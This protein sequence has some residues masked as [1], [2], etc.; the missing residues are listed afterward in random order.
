MLDAKLWGA[1]RQRRTILSFPDAKARTSSSFLG[2]DIPFSKDTCRQERKSFWS[3]TAPKLHSGYSGPLRSESVR[4]LPEVTGTWHESSDERV[5]HDKV[6]IITNDQG[7]RTTPSY[8]AF[9]DTD[10]FVGDSAKNQVSTNPTNTVFDAKRLIGRRFSDVSVQ[11]DIKH[12]PFKVIAGPGDKPMVEVKYKGKQKQ[13]AA[14]EISSMVLKKKREIAEAFVGTAVT[15]AV[16]TVPAYFSDSQRQ[17]TEEAATQCGLQVLKIIAE[18][19]AAAIAYGLDRQQQGGIAASGVKNV[20]IFDLGGG[21]C[22]VSLLAIE[23]GVIRV[24]ATD[25]NTRLGGVDFNNRMVDYFVEEFKRKNK[26]DISG[27]ARALHRLRIACESAKRTLSSTIQTSIEIDYLSEGVNFSSTITRARFEQLNMDLFQKCIEHVDTCLAKA[28]ID[29]TAVDD[30]VIIGG[31]SRIPKLQQLLQDFF[32][33]KNLC[34]H[35]NADEA[36]ASGAAIQAAILSGVCSDKAEDLVILDLKPCSHEPKIATGQNLPSRAVHESHKPDHELHLK[37]YKTLFECNGCKT[38]GFGLMYRCE[39][40]SFNLHTDCILATSTMTTSKTPLSNSS[41]NFQSTAAPEMAIN[42][43]QILDAELEL[44]DKE[45]SGKCL[46]CNKKRLK[47]SV[48]G[49]SGWSYVSACKTYNC[50]A[51]CSTNMLLEKWE[52]ADSGNDCLVPKNVQQPIKK[53]LKTKKG[54]KG[55]KKLQMAKKL[56]ENSLVSLS[57]IT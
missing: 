30:V 4:L 24:R 47:G 28:K 34:R 44:S 2:H 48:T 29:R 22:D 49:N 25:G 23:N 18:P 50:H 27:N 20:L 33:G 41:L 26:I 17:A 55:N 54:T 43:L 3:N 7:N 5:M 21:T 32:L 53:Q 51:Y 11:S 1:R 31:S 46:W 15:N 13:V 10:S 56:F 35:I 57:A 8:V 39:L 40:C 19:T 37:N 36:V 9:T 14:E 52:K 6:E 42:T 45:L 12:W 38:K 16:I